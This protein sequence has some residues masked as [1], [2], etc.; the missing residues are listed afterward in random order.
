MAKIIEHRPI[1]SLIVDDD[2]SIGE[3]LKELV[4][5]SG[6][7]VEAFGD[8]QD[9]IE[10]IKR[11]PVDIVITDLMMPKVG[12]LEIL[13]FAKN[14]NPDSVVIIITGYA[15]LETAI[16]AVREGAYDYIKKPFKLQEVEIAFNNAVERIELVRRN[17][18]LLLE[19]KDAYD[20]LVTLK[21]VGNKVK[22]EDEP[23]SHKIAYLNFFSN[24]L[25]SLEFLHKAR[26][27]QQGLFERLENI[28]QLKKDGLLTEAEF[29][30]LKRHVIKC[31]G[32]SK[33]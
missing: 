25:P 30:K 14:T 7:S 28:S 33:A 15:S 16:E 21:K 18:E 8:G 23:E 5:R 13:H 26:E 2:R 17:R 9:A 24:A 19:L 6:V 32:G 10:F 31:V 12:G 1:Q 20:Q 4:S 29:K 11:Q 3:I 22:D 27:E